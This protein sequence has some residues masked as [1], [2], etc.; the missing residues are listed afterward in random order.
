MAGQILASLPWLHLRCFDAY[1]VQFQIL[2]LDLVPAS[3]EEAGCLAG[4]SRC[5]A[6]AMSP[7]PLSPRAREGRP[8]VP[9]GML[10]PKLCG[11]VVKVY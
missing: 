8:W 11:S 3:Q 5:W 1:S 7:S 6:A 9:H 4:L 2:H 10:D